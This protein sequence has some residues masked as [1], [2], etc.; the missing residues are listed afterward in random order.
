MSDT[1]TQ[2][3][4]DYIEFTMS[5][6]A[7]A[8]T[9][10]GSAFGWEFTDYG[11]EYVGI[12]GEPREMGG[13]AKGEPVPGGV[14]VVL[15]SANLDETLGAVRKAG[16]KITKEPFRFPGG[17]RFHFADPSGNELAVWTQGE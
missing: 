1:P 5:D 12:K 11:P 4:I 8:K 16:G 2:H 14:L 13:F 6:L 17:R 7:A 9:F 10:Y 3:A 15:Y